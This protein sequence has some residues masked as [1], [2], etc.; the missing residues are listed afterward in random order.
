MDPL[1]NAQAASEHIAKDKTDSVLQYLIKWQEFEWHTNWIIWPM[2]GPVDLI[3]NKDLQAI[4][5]HA[6]SIHTTQDLYHYVHIVHWKEL[7]VPLLDATQQAVRS[8]QPPTPVIDHAKQPSALKNQ[9]LSSKRQLSDG[10]KD[11]SN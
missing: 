7:S 2:Y 5:K 9:P 11:D 4:A 6:G 1:G 10:S 8:I 3:S